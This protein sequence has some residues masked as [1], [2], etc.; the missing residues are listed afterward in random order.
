MAMQEEI[1]DRAFRVCA[2]IRFGVMP[3]SWLNGRQWLKLALA[4]AKRHGN[5]ELEARLGAYLDNAW[6]KNWN[7]PGHTRE[8]AA[9]SLNEGSF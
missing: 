6:P 3:Q 1:A 9:T 7:M 5:G 8:N 2:D 4:W